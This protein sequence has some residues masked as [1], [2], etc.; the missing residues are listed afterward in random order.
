MLRG[1]IAPYIN[2]FKQVILHRLARFSCLSPFT[3]VKS[4]PLLIKGYTY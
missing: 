4:N 2:Y 1:L 3:L